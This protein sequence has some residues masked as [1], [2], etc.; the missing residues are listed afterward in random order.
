MR[1]DCDLDHFI[2]GAVRRANTGWPWLPRE[3][4]ARPWPR[5]HAAAEAPRAARPGFR[6]QRG[7]RA[8]RIC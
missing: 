3:E 7:G 1:A 5:L 8:R 6:G 4:G 2:S